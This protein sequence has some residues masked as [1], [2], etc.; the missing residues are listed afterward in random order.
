MKKSLVS[1]LSDWD[2]W[3]ADADKASDGWQSDYPHWV[4]LMSMAIKAMEQPDANVAAIEKCWLISEEDE[5]LAEHVRKNPSQHVKL[6]TALASSKYPSVRW[7]VYSSLEAAGPFGIH[8]LEIG[9]TDPDAYARRRAILAL[10]KAQPG[11]ALRKLN[12]LGEDPDPTNRDILSKLK[13]DL[14]K[15]EMLSN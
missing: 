5:W 11:S 3:A 8:I 4:E 2:T 14:S 7:Q 1:L 9:T 10:A 12:E 13:N 15:S 6:L